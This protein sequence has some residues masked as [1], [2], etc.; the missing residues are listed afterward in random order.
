M[1]LRTIHHHGDMTLAVA[2]QK[3]RNR[4]NVTIHFPS[5]F[6]AQK[7]KYKTHI[8]NDLRK[9]RQENPAGR[10]AGGRA[11]V[12]EVM[13][14]VQVVEKQSAFQLSVGQALLLLAVCFEKQDGARAHAH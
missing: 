11:M 8:R 12:N 2:D 14:N 9:G 6:Y 4:K 3:L 1:R 13:V 5:I 10:W 7:Y